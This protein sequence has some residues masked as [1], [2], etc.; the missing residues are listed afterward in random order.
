IMKNRTHAVGTQV[1]ARVWTLK[2]LSPLLAIAALG[3][4]LPTA[5][6]Q[7]PVL[8]LSNKWSLAAGSRWDLDTGNLTR[9]VA[10]NKLTGNVLLASRVSSNHVSVISGVD[11]SDLGTLN[12]SGI[13][14]GTLGLDLVGVADDGVI[15]A[16]NLTASSSSILKIY[17]WNSEQDGA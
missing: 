5:R 14:G 3:P 12:S 15:Y 1:L 6:A 10:I 11:G 9:G 16:A 8:I 17:R 4:L 7:T 13:S 2:T